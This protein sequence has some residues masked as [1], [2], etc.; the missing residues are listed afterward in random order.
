MARIGADLR[1]QDFIE[2][3]LKV[4][5]EH[6]VPNATTRRIAAAANSPLASLHYVFHLSL[7][8]I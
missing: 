5:A 4:I 3:T 2:A 6:G 7:I 8:H 1:R